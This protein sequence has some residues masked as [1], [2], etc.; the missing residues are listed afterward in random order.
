MWK[1]L[2]KVRRALWVIK[3][4]LTYRPETDGLPVSDL[5]VWRNSED[6]ETFFELID[7]GGLFGN[8]QDT[9]VKHVRLFFFDRNGEFFQEEKVPLALNQRGTINLSSMLANARDSFG[10]FCV[11]HPDAPSNV[12]EFGSFIA[13]RGYLSYRYKKS[14]LKSFVHGNLDAVSLRPNGGI[15]QLGSTSFRKREY[16]LQY[17]LAAEN[18]YEIG[19]VNTSASIQKISCVIIADADGKTLHTETKMVPSK[20]AQVF[21]VQLAQ[22][23]AARVVIRSRLVMARPLVFCFRDQKMDVFHG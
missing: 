19:V 7:I 2:E 18:A 22:P 21:P 13:E 9:G 10:T 1:K 4:P 16:R 17:M 6:W 14:P 12:S 11:F 23:Q 5:F 15:Q 3:Q 20:G 8:L